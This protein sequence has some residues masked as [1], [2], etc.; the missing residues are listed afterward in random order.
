M[1]QTT[2]TGMVL[3]SMPIGDYDKRL[4]ILTKERGKIS[5]FARGARK[6]N[7]AL[8]ACSQPFS[9]GE[10]YVFEGKDSYTVTHA[11]ISQYF[12]ELRGDL[13]A[14]YYG[15]YFCEFASYLTRES[16]DESEVLKLLF[17]TLKALGKNTIPSELIRYIFELKIMSINGEAPQ[18][19]ECVSCGTTTDVYQFSPEKGGLVCINCNQDKAG[20]GLIPLNES[21][22]YA[23]QF[24]IAT[25]IEKLYTFKVSDQVLKELAYCIKR[26]L[27]I[28]V[29]IEFKSL[30]M[31]D[32]L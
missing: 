32:I 20:N 4:V 18:V 27:K 25:P 22:I 6:Q 2:V 19:F 14:I 30:E 17:Q 21:T 23:L 10:F 5:A 15:F 9:F 24:I 26:Y 1:K 31:L 3:A 8:L 16:V 13:K 28:Y 29:N 12:V 11:N 7:S